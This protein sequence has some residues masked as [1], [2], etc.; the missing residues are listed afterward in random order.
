MVILRIPY[1]KKMNGAG[2][3]AD[4]EELSELADARDDDITDLDDTRT[5][6]DLAVA[7]IKR[8]RAGTETLPFW[9][10]VNDFA[11]V[12]RV[13]EY[14]VKNWLIAHG[15]TAILEGPPSMITRPM[16]TAIIAV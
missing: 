5:P 14:L 1:A 7:D 16:I 3:D 11:T 2:T 10:D 15:V 12:D 4:A 8:T 6:V 13:R 9:M